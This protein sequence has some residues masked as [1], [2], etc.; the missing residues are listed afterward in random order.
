M[1][2]FSPLLSARRIVA[3]LQ[4]SRGT[5]CGC[6]HAAAG[7]AV[8]VALVSGPLSSRAVQNPSISIDMITTGNTYTPTADADSDGIPDPGTNHMTLGPIDNCL[9][10]HPPGEDFIHGHSAH[11]VIQNVEDLVGWSARFNY[12]GDQLHLVNFGPTPFDDTFT[13]R[14]VGFLNLP[15]DS[16][17]HRGVSTS[18]S[19]PPA[20]PGPQ[21]ALIGAVYIGSQSL[22]VSPD[23]PQKAVHDEPNRTYGTT[24]GGILADL[25]LR[26]EAGNRHQP[27]LFLNL[28]DGNPSSPGT[29]VDVFTGTGIQIPANQLGDG[30]HG[31]GSTCVPLNCTVN[32]CPPVTPSPTPS[33]SPTP[34]PEGIALDMIPTGNSYAPGVDG[35]SDGLPDP[36]TNHMT[37]GPIDS[38]LTTAAPGSNVQHFHTA[39]LVT[40]NVE[41][42]VG[43]TARVNYLGDQMRPSSVN[44]APFTDTFTFQSV[45]FTNLPL[46][47]AFGV[48]RGLTTSANIPPAAPGPQTA[49][50]GGVYAGP[51]AFAVSPDTPQKVPHDEANQTY[52][53]T[54]GGVLAAVTLEVRPGNAGQPSLFA[55]LDDGNPNTP[56]SSV[57]V[58]TGSGT[59]ELPFP[60]NQLGDGFHGEGATCVPQDCTVNECQFSTPGPTDTP[61]PSPPPTPTPS[62]FPQNPRIAID[63]VTTGNGYVPG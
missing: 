42:L 57:T 12:M 25:V 14:L 43:W 35:N 54:G 51:Y 63:M 62:P 22:A 33:P 1:Q 46:V 26:V 24:G 56:G 55:N 45:G 7:V 34:G 3:A 13:G 38:C 41:D 20:T 9:T 50:F 5:E 21:T 59:T 31:E 40:Q 48:H 11:L 58:F 23:T 32:E 44:I 52:G 8:L 30:Y 10:T 17:T 18:V 27:S 36:G 60:V 2:W 15:I 28:D 37:I 29:E 61:T 19:I 47:G 16:G 6:A 39:H 4:T 49:H 53:T